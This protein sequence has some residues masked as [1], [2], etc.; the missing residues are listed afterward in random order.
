MPSKPVAPRSVGSPATA[1]APAVLGQVLNL[2]SWPGREGLTPRYRR[3]EPVVRLHARSGLVLAVAA[4]RGARDADGRPEERFGLGGFLAYSGHSLT[5]AGLVIPDDRPEVAEALGPRCAGRM[6]DTPVGPRPWRFLRLS[7]FFHYRT[8]LFTQRIYLGAGWLVVAD[9]GRTL[10]LC[11]EAWVPA[12]HRFWREGFTLHVP[13]WSRVTIDDAGKERRKNVGHRPP[14]RVKPV[15]AHGYMAAFASAGA[16]YGKRNPDGSAYQGRFLDVVQL[17][18]VLDGADSGELSDHL[19]AFGFERLDAPAAVALDAVG[20]ETM[21]GCVDAIW[22]LAHRLDDEAALWLTSSHDRRLGQARLDLGAAYSAGTLASEIVRRSGVRSPLV[23][24]KTPNDGDLDS[25]TA[26]HRG[27]WLSC[28]LAAAGLLPVA[29]IDIHGAYPAVASLLG[30]WCVM[31]A[32]H[33]RRQDV[34][35]DVLRLCEEAAAGDVRRLLRPETWKR[36]G[37]VL[38]EVL[39]DGETWPVESPDRDYPDGHAAMRPVRSPIPL[40][41]SWPD[42]VLAALRARRVPRV[43]AAT[44]LVPVGRQQ[45]LRQGWPLY[46]GKALRIGED[47]AVALVHLR[48]GAKA[49]D[50]KRLAA[51]LKVLTN[52]ACYGNPARIDPTYR[53]EGRHSV[54][55]ERPFEHSFPPVGAT[56]TSGTRLLVGIAEHLIGRAGG[57][58]ASRDTDGLLLVSSPEGGKVLLLDGRE[59]GAIS[60]PALDGVLSKFNRLDP[61]GDGS[62]FW[63]PPEREHEGRPLHGLVLGIKRYALA[64]LDDKGDLAEIVE[65]TEHG[66]AGSVTDPPGFTG[67]AGDGRHRWTREVAAFAVR[68]TVARSRGERLLALWPWDADGPFPAIECCQAA[69]PKR[70]DEL[71]SRLSL[72]PFGLYA[73]GVVKYKH[74]DTPVA[75]DSGSD[76]SDWRSLDWRGLDGEPVQPTVDAGEVA[77][78]PRERTIVL[79]N[80]GGKAFRWTRPRLLNDRAE[81]VVE[82][83]LI[84]RVGRSG[85]LLEAQLAD[86]GTDDASDLRAVYD[87]GQAETYLAR[88]VKALGPRVFARAAGVSPGVARR[89]EVGAAVRPSTIRRALANLR[90]ASNEAPRCPTDARPVFRLSAL[91]CSS[92]CRETAKKRRQREKAAL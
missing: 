15:A 23:K 56:V 48:D 50:D 34:L 39:P 81:V 44:R 91:Y 88:Q 13:T 26:A 82:P 9:L 25:W 57:S 42:V 72:R 43:L 54:L 31:T 4:E 65:A 75:L 53:R 73:S 22:H 7:E 8:G 70:L 85:R 47:P 6:V 58:V 83:E 18:D 51:M 55:R 90:L 5:G 78:S 10:G 76:L 28:E 77:G 86:P 3:H 62:P 40:P 12:Q 20:A 60:W 84:R 38:C 71:S 37:L 30:W 46:G 74:A 61:W 52:S 87:E 69:S 79:S 16:G 41:F 89:I 2:Q 24:F 63:K 66:L 36:L 80:L 35:R 17:G 14:V 29:D 21:A 68:E 49:T 64:V 67:R 32:A 92:R 33:L 1:G 27:G 11:A 59:V 45:G 19:E